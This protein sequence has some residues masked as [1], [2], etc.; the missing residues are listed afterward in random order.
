MLVTDISKRKQRPIATYD[1]AM[2]SIAT[3]DVL[4]PIFYKLSLAITSISIA[5]F[6]LLSLSLKEAAGQTRVNSIISQFYGYRRDYYYY[7]IQLIRYIETRCGGSVVSAK[8]YDWVLT[9]ALCYPILF[10]LLIWIISGVAPAGVSTTLSDDVPKDKR[11]LVL[12]ALI[13]SVVLYE[14]ASRVSGVQWAINSTIAVALLF[15]ATFLAQSDGSFAVLAAVC[16][17]ATTSIIGAA[18]QTNQ[19]IKRNGIAMVFIGGALG[20]AVFAII[21]YFLFGRSVYFDASVVIIFIAIVAGI[22]SYTYGLSTKYGLEWL[23]HIIQLSLMLIFGVLIS[24]FFTSTIV[25]STFVAL[26]VS[27]GILP[28][29]NA[30]FDWISL[31]V[32][33]ILLKKM[34]A[35]RGLKLFAMCV[36]DWIIGAFLLFLV[37]GFMICVL[38]V[39]HGV[40]LA[41]GHVS[42][43]NPETIIH[44]ITSE[45]TS[46]KS[47]WIYLMISSTLWP[48][49][50]H[51]AAAG[52]SIWTRWRFNFVSVER[53]GINASLEKD[54]IKRYTVSA[55][56]AANFFVI[57]MISFLS[58]IIVYSV[59]VLAAPVLG[60]IMIDYSDKISNI[61]IPFVLRLAN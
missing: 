42:F 32:T 21:L 47:Y 61:I 59:V 41:R 44:S 18:R 43:V 51:T 58:I 30:P 3:M 55:I 54:T 19:K 28:F 53:L 9:I 57:V 38:N 31:I 1:N 2:T 12:V 50:V 7:I 52:V 34:I 37:A 13:A 11:L 33:I 60:I 36:K 24:Y 5:L 25:H 46:P 39:Y 23:F 27:W 26:Y 56:I 48:T 15:V 22:F 49:A 4:I 10:Y 17:A 16:V 40:A 8:S 6:G 45:P 35:S 20:G 14:R 29:L